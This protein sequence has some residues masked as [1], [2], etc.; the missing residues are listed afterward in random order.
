MAVEKILHKLA[1]QVNKH[2]RKK[3][4]P[5]Y[6]RLVKYFIGDCSIKRRLSAKG[7]RVG[8]SQEDVKYIT[9]TKCINF[10]TFYYPH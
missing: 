7:Q 8:L 2:G 6:K 4:H 9:A 5:V 10:V 1:F 3:Q